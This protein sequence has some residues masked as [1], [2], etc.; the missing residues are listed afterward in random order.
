MQLPGRRAVSSPP[1]R[2]FLSTPAGGTL[3]LFSVWLNFIIALAN[4]PQRRGRDTA[5]SQG[6]VS[7]HHSGSGSATLQIFGDYASRRKTSR[8]FQR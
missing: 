3:S 8:F 2:G 5:P 1:F 6:Q 7:L 4:L